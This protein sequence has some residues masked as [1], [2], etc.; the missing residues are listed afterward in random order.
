[1]KLKSLTIKGY[2][3]INQE[4]AHLSFGDITVLLGANGVGKSNVVSFFSML[5]YAMTGALQTFVAERGFA[6]SFLYFGSKNTRQIQA[7]VAFLDN[8]STDC[9]DFTLTHAAG[10]ILLFTEE[11]ITYH[12]LS[13]KT[14]YVITLNPAV[15]E[16]DLLQIGKRENSSI[17]DKKVA[18]IV[19]SLLR[20]CRVFHFHDTTL[21]AKIRGQGYIEDNQYLNHDAGNLA[22]FLFRL[23]NNTETVRHYDRIVRYVQKAMPQ[24][25]DFELNPTETNNKYI[26]LNWREKS[27]PAYLF[28]PHQIS[29]GSLR[30]MALAT[31][32]LQPTDLIPSVIVLDEPELGLHP[33]AIAYLAG[34]MKT[35]SQH[36]QII[37]ATQ[38]QR[39]VD[40]FEVDNIVVVEKHG[41]STEFKRKTEADLGNWLEDYSLS[42]LW[43][44]NVLGGQP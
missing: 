26:T 28:G 15:R 9:Y 29:D 33:S 22:A 39:L 19:L 11:K 20:K 14:P 3:S 32:F 6:D 5:N 41:N 4:G 23:K 42:E 16:S 21:N 12:K 17:N 7:S 2:K 10:D 18:S 34:M 25:G 40:E 43:E 13:T 36:S 1:M 27:N 35:A 38:S 31:L 8:E 24:F 44:K 30:F 37:V